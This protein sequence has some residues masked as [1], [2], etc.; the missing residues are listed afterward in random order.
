VRAGAGDQRRHQWPTNRLDVSTNQQTR[1][2]EKRQWPK[3]KAV[4]ALYTERTGHQ[5]P[6]LNSLQILRVA[7][8]L[9]HVKMKAQDGQEDVDMI[10]QRVFL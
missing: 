4:K 7:L 9:H 10:G 1:K 5:E 2:S 6:R 3:L 8:L